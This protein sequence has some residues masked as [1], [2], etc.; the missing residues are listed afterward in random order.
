MK[1]VYIID[2]LR[3]DGTQ[4]W[5]TQLVR[6]LA[7]RGHTQMVIALNDSENDSVACDLRSAGCAVWSVGKAGLITNAGVFSILRYLRNS[8]VDV[9]VTLLFVSDVLGRCLARAAR[10]PRIVSSIRARNVHY[11][12]WQRLL[13]RATMRWAD[14]VVLNSAHVREFAVAEEGASTERIAIIPNSLNVDDYAR[15]MSREELCAEFG[16]SSEW[17]IIGSVGRLTR[18]KGFDLLLRALAILRRRDVH[19][20]LIGVGEE[21]RN[22]RAQAAE[23]G[24]TDY[25]HFAGY[26]SDVPHLLGVLDLYVQPSRFEGMPNALLEAMAAN[27]PVVATAVDGNCEL[28]DDGV[29]GWLVPVENV[30]ALANAIQKALD[31]SFETARRAAMAQQRVT[32]QYSV[33]VMV[34]T[35]EQVLHGR[36]DWHATRHAGKSTQ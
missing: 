33:Q 23:L 25:V 19:L 30:G 35:W 32:D 6:G 31:N 18:Q 28:I 8:N 2:H 1:I 15:P 22:L 14:V 5:L 11:A 29:H 16:I 36:Q 4:R 13:A 26:R 10:V 21:E 34:N 24:L 20:L 27:C 12:R 9:V 3:R 7:T 17:R